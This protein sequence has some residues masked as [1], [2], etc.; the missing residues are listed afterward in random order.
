MTQLKFR[1]AAFAIS[2]AAA[3]QLLLGCQPAQKVVGKVNSH[4]IT[5]DEFNARVQRVRGQALQNNNMDAG[6]V[7]LMSLIKA[8]LID[9][10]AADPSVKG[11]PSEQ[12]VK[13]YTSQVLR[14]FPDLSNKIKTGELSLDELTEQVRTNLEQVAIGTDGAK[15][16]EK[17]I[18]ATYDELNAR[19]AADYPALYTIRAITPPSA[20]QATAALEAIKKSGDFTSAA[21]ALQIPKDVA[22][23]LTRTTVFS[24][25]QLP[26]EVTTVLETLKPGEFT[27]QPITITVPDQSNPQSPGAQRFM[28]AQLV[29]K[30]PG[31]TAKLDEIRAQMTEMTLEK[32][33]PQWSQ[34]AA[35][36][37]SEFTLKAKIEIMVDRYKPLVTNYII[38]EAKRTAQAAASPEQSPFSG[39][40]AGSAPA[41]AAPSTG[42]PTTGAT[43]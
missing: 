39:A 14:M 38:P 9:Q 8:S 15:V 2:T 40:P 30:E 23:Q 6:S 18:Q 3:A 41:G 17:E 16:D 43:P 42:A 29:A 36:Q 11:V 26:A 25:K 10:C 28:I 33:F 34:H 32:K 7:T 31:K 24:S 5:E 22:G 20:A 19:H 4:V 37:V 35:K 21:D 1:R 27:P 12:S 13:S